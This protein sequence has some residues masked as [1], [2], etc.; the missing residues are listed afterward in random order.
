VLICNSPTFPQLLVP[1]F[2]RIRR[3]S[4]RI[5]AQIDEQPAD[6][7]ATGSSARKDR[8]F[9]PQTGS[10]APQDRK[11]RLAEILTATF[12]F[13]FGTNPLCLDFGL[14]AISA[15][16]KLPQL[17]QRRWHPEDPSGSF[18]TSTIASSRS[19]ATIIKWYNLLLTCS[20]SLFCVPFLSRVAF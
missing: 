17:R 4:A 13:R 15:T 10:S 19:S 9:R 16:T 3:I 14:S 1:N 8:K 12:V 6:L 7:I 11:F 2:P 18:D 5:S 20:P